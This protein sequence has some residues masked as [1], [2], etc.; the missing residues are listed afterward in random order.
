MSTFTILLTYFLALLGLASATS[1][2]RDGTKGTI[3][4]P[5]AGD[6]IAPGQAFDFQY[7]TMADYG[8]SSYNF[9]VFLVTAPAKSMVPSTEFMQGHYFGRFQEANY[10]AVPYATNP[11]PSQLIMPDLDQSPG[12]WG[13]GSSASNATFYI[14]V[15]EEWGSGEGALGAKM[16]LAV[17][18]IIYNA[19]TSS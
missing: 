17:T 10:P 16:S 12:G 15:L 9:T 7:N 14:A 1:V 11:P 5:S 6:S 13:I 2:P 3:V 4:S 8:S 19:T 18:Q